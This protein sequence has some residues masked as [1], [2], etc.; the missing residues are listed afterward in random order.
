[1]Y[2]VSFSLK[3]PKA[4]K[5]TL[6]YMFVFY[7]GKRIKVSTQQRILPALWDKK[8]RA[9][10]KNPRLINQYQATDPGI[11][12]RLQ[13]I[14]EK[15]NGLKQDVDRFNMELTLKQ[16]PFDL[17]SLKTHLSR[18]KGN[19]IWNGDDVS[20]I[21]K[22]LKAFIGQAES[23]YRK[24]PNGS[25]YSVGTIKNYRN[26]LQA[27]ERFERD[28]G[29]QLVWEDIDKQMY[30]KFLQWHE[31]QGYSK[32]YIGKHV[33]DLKAIM[34]VSH[35][36]GIHTSNEARRRY[37]VTPKDKKKKIPLTLAEVKTLEGLDLMDNERLDFARNIFLL[38]CYLGLRVSDIKRITPQHIHSDKHGK[39]LTI[40]AQ[41]TGTDL[42]VPVSRKADHILNKFEYTIP[43][44]WEQ[45]VNRH[46]KIIGKMICLPPQRASTLTLHVSRHTFAKLSYEM[47]IPSLYIMQI[48]GHA[49]E[50]NFLRY[51]N[52]APEQAVNEFRKH[53]F[54]Y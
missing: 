17:N 32:N 30:Y 8:K 25:N 54:F 31:D 29:A 3:S 48:T 20:Y 15:L 11:E 44:F 36:E 28:I 53:E 23:G 27:I 33:K 5:E 40:K 14:Q 4:R 10:T 9:V 38:G 16:L 6:I 35:E 45:V 49:S 51:I 41:K 13:S 7:N 34:K 22:F 24:Q 18:L 50:K 19:N 39:Y 43:D 21:S 1:M 52:I 42:K 2:S 47:G 26:L 46:L 37:F 12:E